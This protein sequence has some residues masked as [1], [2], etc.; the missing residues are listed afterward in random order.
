MHCKVVEM[1]K[2]GDQATIFATQYLGA[3]NLTKMKENLG[4]FTEGLLMAV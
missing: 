2:S 3:L 1:M 4:G